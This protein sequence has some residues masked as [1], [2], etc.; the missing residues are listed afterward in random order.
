MA[1]DSLPKVQQEEIWNFFQKS[2]A[3]PIAETSLTAR[4][5]EHGP[6][7]LPGAHEAAFGH[8]GVERVL[9]VADALEKEHPVGDCAIRYEASFCREY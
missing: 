3:L 9:A 8:I 1:G 5:C 6:E 2:S 7:L 4:A